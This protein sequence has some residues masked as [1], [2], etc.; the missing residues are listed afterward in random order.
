M[1]IP[2]H[3]ALLADS[4]LEDRS[5]G[6]SYSPPRMTSSTL[7]LAGHEAHGSRQPSIHMRRRRCSATPVLTGRPLLNPSPHSPAYLKSP[8]HT[9]RRTT[10][11]AS[12]NAHKTI[13]DSMTYAS[14]VLSIPHHQQ[15]SRVQVQQARL[16]NGE[17]HSKPEAYAQF[18]GPSPDSQSRPNAPQQMYRGVGQFSTNNGEPDRVAVPGLGG[19]S[20]VMADSRRQPMADLEDGKNGTRPPPKPQQ[21]TIYPPSSYHLAKLSKSAPQHS[22]LAATS[23]PPACQPNGLPSSINRPSLPGHGVIH[24]TQPQSSQPILHGGRP[25]HDPEFSAKAVRDGAAES[26]PKPS[27]I[28]ASSTAQRLPALA[29]SANGAHSDAGY[30]HLRSTPR[31]NSS[32]KSSL[33]V[34]TEYSR[35]SSL[36]VDTDY[37]R[38][39]ARSSG[40]L[41]TAYDSKIHPS[42]PLTAR[43][44]P[45]SERTP[46]MENA[47]L[48]PI[49]PVGRGSHIPRALECPPMS[50]IERLHAHAPLH[51]CNV[52]TSDLDLG[53]CQGS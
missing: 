31:R 13:R 19:S 35:K 40:Q 1:L 37:P 51:W 38:S 5:G 46:T 16:S 27:Y 7:A 22:A 11:P 47:D 45:H 49:A 9:P 10:T 18:R 34:D 41:G 3:P 2:T 23:N 50:P 21:G 44:L 36:S 52:H 14:P 29:V 30:Q 6:Y 39:V 20:N 48:T 25:R 24:H 17:R 43:P 26:W 15:P 42:T 33:S 8:L 28:Q 53:E 12:A 4:G 32:R